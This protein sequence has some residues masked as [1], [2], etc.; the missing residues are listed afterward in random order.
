M[1]GVIEVSDNF[2]DPIKIVENDLPGLDADAE[3][4]SSGGE[5]A[6]FLSS[7]RLRM[8]KDKKLLRRPAKSRG[9]SP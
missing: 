2:D 5:E 9:N 8:R 7:T 6:A 3:E 1:T 4:S